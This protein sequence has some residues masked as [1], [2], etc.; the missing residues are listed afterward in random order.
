MSGEGSAALLTTAG[1]EYLLTL[2]SLVLFYVL[3]NRMNFA[4]VCV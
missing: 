4:L 2:N 3:G 1:V